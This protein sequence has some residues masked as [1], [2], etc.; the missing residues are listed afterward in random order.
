[1]LNPL[2]GKAEILVFLEDLNRCVFLRAESG[3]IRLFNWLQSG[4][5]ERGTVLE[6]ENTTY[7]PPRTQAPTSGVSLLEAAL[8]IVV[9]FF[10]V[11]FLGGMLFIFS[12]EV[13]LV[14]GELLILIIP[15]GY[16][17]FKRI[18]IKSY[19]K[20]DLKPRFFLIGVSMGIVLLFLD[21]IIT[22]LLTAIFGP[23]QAVEESNR[24]IIDLSKSPVGLVAVVASLSLAGICEE[25]AFRGFLQNT[26][27]R[28]YSFLPA[29]LVS[30]VVFGLFH[31][32]PQA[33]YTVSAFIVGLFLGFIYHHWNS[34]LVSATAHSTVNIIVIVLLLAL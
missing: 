28:R 4:T 9:T 33:V 14:V 7:P 32:D 6:N 23:S 3:G 1:M 10:S 17:L 29:V 27:N 2:R 34:Y 15:L 16:L 12:T 8:V 20:A 24:I 18:K 25:F 30:A 21:I 22:G 19:I 31:F 5:C 11:L 26:I 13:A